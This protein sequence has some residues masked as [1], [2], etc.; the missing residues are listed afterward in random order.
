MAM[1]KWLRDFE[2]FKK[3]KLKLDQ[4]EGLVKGEMVD[5]SPYLVNLLK[6]SYKSHE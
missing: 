6:D 3:V 2:C 4:T 1:N 5:V